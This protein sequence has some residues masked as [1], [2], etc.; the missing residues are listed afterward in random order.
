MSVIMEAEKNNLENVGV[1]SPQENNTIPEVKPPSPETI[2]AANA[3]LTEIKKLK[4]SDKISYNY[5]KSIKLNYKDGSYADIERNGV[6]LRTVPFVW[7]TDVESNQSWA[8]FWADQF[9]GTLRKQSTLPWRRVKRRTVIIPFN[10]G[11]HWTEPLIGGGFKARFDE[12]A[13]AQIPVKADFDEAQLNEFIKEGQHISQNLLLYRQ[14]QSYLK[15]KANWTFIAILVIAI[16]II[17]V[18][19]WLFLTHPHFL[20]SLGGMVGGLKT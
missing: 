17:A 3:G 6:V 4:Q 18:G 2:N 12:N 19:A 20:S 13:Q 9:Y 8:F 11:E 5:A 16:V 14:L 7:K 1:A 15:P 10:K